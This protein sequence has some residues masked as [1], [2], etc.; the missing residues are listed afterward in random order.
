MRKKLEISNNISSYSF[1]KNKIKSV[2]LNT[3]KNLNTILKNIN[4][5]K[6]FFSTL[7][8]NFKLNFKNS[9][10]KKFNKFN[11]IVIIGM[12]G[13]ILGSKAIYSFLHKKIKKKIIFC[14]NLNDK[15]LDIVEK[16]KQKKILFIIASKSGNTIET[17]ANI[18]LLIKSKKKSENVIVISENKNNTLNNFSKKNKIKFIEHR[19]YISGRYSVLTEVG[20]LP[21]L[22]MG[23]KLKLFRNNLLKFFKADKNLMANSVAKLSQIYLSKKIKSIILLNYSPEFLDFNYWC[24]QLIA[25]SL[26]KNGKGLLPVVSEAP[27]DHHSLLQ[28]YLDGPKD[29]IFYIFSSEGIAS[30]KIKNNYFNSSYNFF[31]KKKINQITNSQK[32]ALITVLKEKKIPY[33]EFKVRECTEVILGELFVYFMVETIMLGKAINVNPFSQPGVERVKIIT[34]KNL[35]N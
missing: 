18:N 34:K 28:L 7:S 32:N 5:K 6:D 9:E 10:V 15:N 14:D 20:M 23:L 4:K 1:D 24:Q 27:K 12:G 16:I 31:K 33:R 21:A 13:S 8:K 11:N 17:L 26:G 19:N 2:Y 30:N 29:K 35:F 22:L 3:K 25:E